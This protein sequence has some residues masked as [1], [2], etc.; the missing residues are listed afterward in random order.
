VLLGVIGAITPWNYP[1]LMAVWKLIP[2]IAAGCTMVLK[3]SELA[4]LSS[5]ILGEICNEAG[6]P[7]GALNIVPGLGPDAGTPL[8]QHPDVDKVSFTGSVPTAQKVM[9]GAALGPRGISLELGGK[10]PLIAF[11]DCDIPSAVDW[12][13]TGILWGSGQVCSATSRVYLHESI[14]QKVLDMVVEKMKGVKIGDSLST[15]MKEHQGPTMGPVVSKVQYDKILAYINEAKEEGLV[16]LA[17]GDGALEELQ[18]TTGTAGFFIPPTIIVDPPLTAK[19]WIEEIFGPVLC[20]RGFT[21]EASV[22]ACANDTEFG[23]AAAVFSASEDTCDRVCRELRTG[24]LCKCM[25]VR[26][27]ECMSV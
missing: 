21:D 11:A 22:V 27:Y 7:K 8:T 12:I 17:G 19:V 20:V 18:K 1:F 4:P 15:E 23:L 6:L 3:P 26:A 2:A 10:S 13:L 24:E 9:M 25:S 16:F 5:I 14:K